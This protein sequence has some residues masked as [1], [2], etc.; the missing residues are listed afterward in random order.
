MAKVFEK[1]ST[2]YN[3][4]FNDMADPRV[5]DWTLMSDPGIVLLMTI[6]YIYV[7][8]SFG[9]RYMQNRKAFDLRKIII[10]YNA[11]QVVANSL[12]FYKILSSGWTTTLSLGCEPIDYS[13]GP[14]AVSL[15]EGFWWCFMLKSVELIETVFFILRKKQN[16]VSFLHVYHHAST[17]LFVWV[18]TKYV[19]GGMTT[20]CVLVN[21]IIHVAMYTYYLLAALGNQTIQNAISKWKKY[22]TTAQ[23]VQFVIVVAH[24]MQ[25]LSPKC[26]VP[27]GLLLLFIPNVLLVFALFYDFYRKAYK[28]KTK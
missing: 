27:K 18:A 17:L 2:G 24:Q 23:M 20:F 26:Q 1:F 13:D 4:L 3:T 12:I 6:T 25:A 16:Q 9:P 11:F 22:L 15:V 5:K 21:S 28:K 10:G 14:N 19:G 7:V 8:V